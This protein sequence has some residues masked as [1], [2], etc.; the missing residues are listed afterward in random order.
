MVISQMRT[1]SCEFSDGQLHF[2]CD[3]GCQPL[4][5]LRLRQGFTVTGLELA[6]KPTTAFDSQLLVFA[7][8]KF[9]TLGQIAGVPI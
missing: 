3:M 9:Q 5:S 4:F 6:E 7:D 8:V 2:S 1:L